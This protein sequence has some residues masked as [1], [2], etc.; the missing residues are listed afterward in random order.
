MQ[1]YNSHNPKIL[2]VYA[3]PI[4]T[5]ISAQM[6]T[7]IAIISGTDSDIHKRKTALLPT[8][9]PALGKKIW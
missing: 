8:T 3:K 7:L 4:D 5:L 1:N 9:P 2:A 6:Q